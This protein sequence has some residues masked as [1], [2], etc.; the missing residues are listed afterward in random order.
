MDERWTDIPRYEGRYEAST[1]GRI[2]WMSTGRVLKPYAN[3]AGYL[4]VQLYHAPN[5][6]RSLSVARL[7]ARTWL[8][9]PEPGQQVNHLDGHKPNNAVANL[10]WVTQSEN[11]QHCSD[12][13]LRK[14]RYGERHGMAKLTEVSVREIKSRLPERTDT[15]LGAEYGVAGGTI[16]DI[17]RGVTWRHL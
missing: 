8:G 1:L 11:Q 15:E 5:Q 7:I 6:R 13:G 14:P 9:E 4:L 10:Q 3:W 12:T 16:R 2:R 17:R